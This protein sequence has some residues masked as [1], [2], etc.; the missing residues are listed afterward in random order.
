MVPSRSTTTMASGAASSRLRKIVAP[1]L[2]F[3][4]SSSTGLRSLTLLPLTAE[5]AKGAL[6]STH[7]TS[8]VRTAAGPGNYNSELV[9]RPQAEM[10]LAHSGQILCATFASECRLTQYSNAPNHRLCPGFFCTPRSERS[11]SASI[12]SRIFNESFRRFR[13]FPSSSW[14]TTCRPTTRSASS[15]SGASCL[16]TLSITHNLPRA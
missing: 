3:I 6:I 1:L 4:A 14:A 15:C 16:G 2:W 13:L 10:A 11:F 9:V 12:R 7:H 8:C 5:L